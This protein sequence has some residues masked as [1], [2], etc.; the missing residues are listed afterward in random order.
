MDKELG[1]FMQKRTFVF[2]HHSAGKKDVLG[3]AMVAEAAKEKIKVRVI[4]C[5]RK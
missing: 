3:K 1:E 2:L 5:D 4:S